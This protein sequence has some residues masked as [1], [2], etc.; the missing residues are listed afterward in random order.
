MLLAALGSGCER[1]A[2][3]PRPTPAETAATTPASPEPTARRESAPHFEIDTTSTKVGPE[4][5]FLQNRDGR[6]RLRALLT[7]QQH[8]VKG[9][10]VPLI[11]QRKVPVPWVAQYVEE[12]ARLDSARIKIRSET[13]PDY[14]AELTFTPES[15]V[16]A[17]ACS[18]V[19]MVTDD[20]GTAVWRLSGGVAG[21]RGRG[22]AGPDLS[23]TGETIERLAKACPNAPAFLVG[24][25]EGIEWGLAYDLAASSRELEKTTFETIVLLGSPPVPGHPVKLA[26]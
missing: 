26:R 23:M 14:D 18:V 6:E 12:L 16:E 2:A 8:F 24:V 9:R 3:K 17:S 11:V 5:A 15:K 10:D 4:R 20:Y 7:E 21:K 13:R 1:E 19:A 25:A 22:M